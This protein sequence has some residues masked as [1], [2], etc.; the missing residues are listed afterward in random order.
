[1]PLR[2]RIAPPLREVL[3]AEGG[4]VYTSRIGNPQYKGVNSL[5][6]CH[7]T[8]GPPEG[9]LAAPEPS[10]PDANTHPRDDARQGDPS[11]LRQ[12]S[13]DPARPTGRPP[14]RVPG[15]TLA[16][17]SSGGRGLTRPN[18]GLTRHQGGGQAT[19]HLPSVL[20]QGQGS[21]TAKKGAVASNPLPPGGKGAHPRHR[22][23]EVGA[24]GPPTARDPA[25]GI[26]PPS[27]HPATPGGVASPPP[28]TGP[29]RGPRRAPKGA[30][31][32]PPNRS[33]R[34]GR[35]RGFVPAPGGPGVTLP[36][37]AASIRG[38]R[39]FIRALHRW[40]LPNREEGAGGPRGGGL[41]RP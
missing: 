30:Q 10:S 34:P 28:R 3:G 1:M 14:T 32:P 7:P 23:L 29:Q 31:N 6:R 18:Q 25:R 24:K 26:V 2:R 35:T 13:A 36:R 20:D 16:L 38:P 19:N 39:T 15:S 40:G 21:R 27:G 9:N 8:A 11:D 41:R 12:T 17:E 33:P 22:P 4:T 5:H 37:P